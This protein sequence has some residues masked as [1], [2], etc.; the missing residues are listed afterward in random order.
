MIDPIGI[1][2]HELGAKLDATKIKPRLVI[3]G[4]SNALKAVAKVGTYGANKYTEDG[5]EHVPDGI[6]R[7]SDAMLRHLLDEPNGGLDESGLEH[8][9]H[10]AW[11]ALARLE[12]M[13]REANK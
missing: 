11:N 7:Y 12:L 8:A 13:I 1:N 4:F 3:F 9:A 10:V 2:Q 6:N 5:W